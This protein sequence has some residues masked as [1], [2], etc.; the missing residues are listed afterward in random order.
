VWL[1]LAIAL[2]PALDHAQAP[3]DGFAAN[4]NKDEKKDLKSL[5]DD[6]TKHAK[7]AD[8]ADYQAKALVM[9][10]MTLG[11]LGYGVTFTGALDER[12]REAVDAHQ[13]GKTLEMLETTL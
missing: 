5:Q 13:T 3:T 2:A 11:K 6:W 4:L 8:F 10:Q 7:M 1:L 9:S 12:T